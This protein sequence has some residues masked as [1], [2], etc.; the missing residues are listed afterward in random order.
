[1]IESHIIGTGSYLPE[2]ILTNNDLASMV[3]TNDEWIVSRTGIKQR[4]IAGENELNADMAYQAA[5]KAIESAHIQAQDISMIIVA[6]TTPDYTFPSVAACVQAKLGAK[7]PAFDMQAVCSGFVY[8]MSTAH[9]FIQSGS[10]KH[11]LVIGSE[12]MS[13]ILDW[14]DRRTCILF[15]D[16]AGAV[17]LGAKPNI[18]ASVSNTPHRGILS[19]YLMA[20]GQHK[21][22]LYA[23]GGVASTQSA[24]VIHMNGQEVFKHAVTK[25]SAAI[26]QALKKAGLTKDAI[27]WLVPHQ[28]NQRIIDSLGKKMKL[29]SDRVIS[30]VANHANTSAAS[31]PLALDYAAQSSQFKEGDLLCFVAIG[32]G[33][34]WGACLLRW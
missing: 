29:E 8:A 4:H 20:Q 22:I 3:D 2:K 31:I 5:Q 13:S 21:D 11:I 14:K 12:K 33:L 28:A 6:T 15:G 23:D 19:S 17:V 16:G 32:G 27:D 25:M 10:M 9:Q 18:D 24:G 7:C 1:M 30:C 26:N 34:T